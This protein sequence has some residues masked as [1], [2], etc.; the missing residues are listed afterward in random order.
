MNM[1]VRLF[2]FLLSSSI[3]FPIIAGL[4]RLRRIKKSSYQPFFILILVGAFMELLNVFLIAWL[5]QNVVAVNIY[6]FFEWLLIAWQFRNWGLLRG[7]NKAFFTLLLLPCLVWVIE[8]LVFWQIYHFA[9][10]YQV[11]YCFLI[12][13]FSVNTINFMITHDYRNIFGNP[14]FLICIAFIIYF[15]YNLVFIW[16]YQ[17]SL[18]GATD[19]TTFIIM[20]HSYINALTNIIFAI[21]LLRIPRPQKFSL[22]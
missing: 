10:Y 11:L 9:T 18:K 6:F 7:R 8:Y 1:K 16:A 21:A 20:L 19:T 13:I 3:I 15:I 14:T 2:L 22:N 17:T 12:V 5:H 4:V